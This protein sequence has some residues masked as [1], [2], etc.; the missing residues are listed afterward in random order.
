MKQL[1]MSNLKTA[2][3]HVGI[4]I[5]KGYNDLKANEIGYEF[6][7]KN[8]LQLKYQ[9]C[10]HNRVVEL[11]EAVKILNPE[12]NLKCNFGINDRG[13]YLWINF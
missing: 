7:E 3:E 5:V 1:S 2:F 11:I 6:T 13:H 10:D 12:I 4:K 9:A 8:R